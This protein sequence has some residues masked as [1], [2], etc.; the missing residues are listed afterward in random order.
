MKPRPLV[1]WLVALLASLPSSYASIS[2]STRSDHEVVQL[3]A[4]CLAFQLEYRAY[5]AENNWIEELT[6]QSG[7]TLNTRKILFIDIPVLYDAQRK[8]LP[9][10]FFLDP[11]Q[12]PYVYHYPGTQNTNE[13]DIYSMGADGKTATGGNDMDDINNWNKDRPWHR[14]YSRQPFIRPMM[15]G[16]SLVIMVA[17]LWAVGRKRGRRQ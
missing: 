6:A 9:R 7:A 17:V 8:S 15:I 2:R 1:L 13:S 11:W 12:H 10:H 5:P 4:A 14:Y 3:T 16:G